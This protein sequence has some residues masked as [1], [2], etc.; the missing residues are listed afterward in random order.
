MSAFFFLLALRIARWCLWRP[1]IYGDSSKSYHSSLARCCYNTYFRSLHEWEYPRIFI[2]LQPLA[3]M[4]VLIHPLFNSLYEYK[5][6][7]IFYSNHYRI[8]EV[9]SIPAYFCIHETKIWILCI[10]TIPELPSASLYHCQLRLRISQL[11]R[12]PHADTT[13]ITFSI[14]TGQL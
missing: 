8:T 2:C 12:T 11:A 13:F 3:F 4:W 7:F 1:P 9:L 6:S 14:S 10:S 5:I